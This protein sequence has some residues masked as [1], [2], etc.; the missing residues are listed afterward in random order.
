MLI[1]ISQEINAIF[2]SAFV[3]KFDLWVGF[4]I[5]AQ[6]LFAVRFLVQWIASEKQGKS[7]I[8][9]AFWFFSIGGGLMTL[10]YGLV[11]EEPIIIMGQGLATIIY[12]RNVILIVKERRQSARGG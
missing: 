8:P 10:I 7:V 1:A 2:Y 12:V 6:L 11:K 3:Q 4:G 9:L 5:I